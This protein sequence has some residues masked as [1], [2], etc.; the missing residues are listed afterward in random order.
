MA[1]KN[2]IIRKNH[3]QSPGSLIYIGKEKENALATHIKCLFYNETQYQHLEIKDIN[4]CILP[5]TDE[6]LWLNVDGIH[7][8]K[9]IED[10][11]KCYHLH[12]LMLEDVLNTNQKPKLEFYNSKIVQTDNLSPKMPKEVLFVTLKMI[13]YNELNNA[14][15]TEHLSL[16]LGKGLVIS[17]QEERKRD[18]FENIYQRIETSV[19][20]TRKNGADYLFYSL[21]DIV[22]DYYFLVI[23]KISEDLEELETEIINSQIE[24]S[25]ITLYST[26]SQITQ[27]RKAVVPLREIMNRLI[28][29][30]SELI[31]PSTNL[32][33]RDV[34]DHITQVLETLDSQREI[35]ASLL[36]L[37]LAQASNKMNNVMKVLTVISVIFMPL[38]FLAGIYGMNF[39]NMPELHW[40]NGYF[41]L[42][43]LMAVLGMGMMVYFKNKKWI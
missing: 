2:K 25:K 33:F 37:Y 23:D 27:M 3:G 13:E 4:Q 42:L 21:L 10:L 7:E 12:P 34:Q 31:D 38:T 5:K 17:F 41:Y 8:S 29:E 15:E 22:V 1:K 39:D 26:K 32:Y 14:I 28:R 20:K 6:I 16:V 40:Q 9:V 35:T 30:E 43:G 24:K 11:G 36:E 18:I 19:G